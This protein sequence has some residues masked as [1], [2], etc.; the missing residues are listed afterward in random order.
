VTT[1]KVIFGFG[2]S[3]DGY[4]ARPDHSVDFLVVEKE[5]SKI[6]ADF[7]RTVDAVIMG[8]KTA[9]VSLQVHGGTFPSQ[10]LSTY[11]FSRSWT[12][13]EGEGFEVVKGTPA[14]LIHRLRKQKG[15]HMFL[16]GG[17]ELGRSFL[18]AD[19]VDEHFIGVVPILL[20][21]G[22]LAFPAGF[23]PRA[24]SLVEC[25][26]YAKGSFALKYKRMRTSA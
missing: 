26:P 18:K 25:R 14:S 22:I 19:L 23:P 15:K 9:E 2:M 10:G 11:V 1:R 21:N 6:M 20:G 24:I 16:T 5:T 8:R 12:P 3:L 7:F 4:I 13:G 17:G